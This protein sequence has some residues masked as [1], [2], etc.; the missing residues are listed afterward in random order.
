MMVATGLAILVHA[1]GLA[2]M[3]FVDRSFFISMTP[4]NLLLMQVLAWWTSPAEKSVHLGS[5]IFLGGVGMM[6]E[7]TGVHT[8]LLFGS[9]AYG[10]HL[11]PKWWNVPLLIGGNWFLVIT[12]SLSLALH[13]RDQLSEKFSGPVILK[14]PALLSIA[15]PFVAALLSTAFDRIMEPA[16][17]KLGFWSWSSGNVPVY[18]YICWFAVSFLVLL[19]AGDRLRP[20]AAVF[21]RRLLLIQAIF[22][23]LVAISR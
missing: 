13:L 10:D 6:A 2:G 20:V 19:V 16:A 12:G 14:R 23:L 17:I 5:L 18:N 7:W 11:G 3:L 8:G 22:F 15:V 21:P 1:V 9:Y 4:V